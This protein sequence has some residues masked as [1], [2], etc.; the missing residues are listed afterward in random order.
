LRSFD[1]IHNYLVPFPRSYKST[2]CRF[3]HIRF[4]KYS[5]LDIRIRCH[6]G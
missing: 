2:F 6:S 5:H 1:V 4:R 3:W